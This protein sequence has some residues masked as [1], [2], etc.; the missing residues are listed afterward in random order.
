M[1]MLMAIGCDLHLPVMEDAEKLAYWLTQARERKG[2]SRHE[3][4]DRL[5]VA[6][7]TVYNWEKAN[8]TPSLLMLGP[9]CDALDVPPAM[10]RDLD[11]P[12]LSPVEAYLE[13]AASEGAREGAQRAARRT[14]Q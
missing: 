5:H 6:Y 13:K 12:P 9:L 14:P 4:A 8:K 7:T 3:L 10:F 2:L 1:M 11:E